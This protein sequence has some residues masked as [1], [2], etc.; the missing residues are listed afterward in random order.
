MHY[1]QIGFMLKDQA[2]L[3]FLW[4]WLTS[5]V[6][7]LSGQPDTRDPL[8]ECSWYFSSQIKSNLLAKYVPDSKYDTSCRHYV[9]LLQHKSQ[10]S[11]P[12]A[13]TEDARTHAQGLGRT[14]SK[15]EGHH[16]SKEI[17]SLINFLSNTSTTPLNNWHKFHLFLWI[18]WGL[19]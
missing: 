12:S 1:Y 2:V 4:L 16:S 6:H 19:Q 11:A 7:S 14:A 10:F 3:T 8:K 15:Q 17:T 13:P 5:Y 18:L 9:A